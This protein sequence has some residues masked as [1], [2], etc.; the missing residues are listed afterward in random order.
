MIILTNKFLKLSNRYQQQVIVHS[1]FEQIIKT[2]GNE[3]I[4]FLEDRIETLITGDLLEMKSRI[5]K[6]FC[7]LTKENKQL[8]KSN[9]GDVTK[10]YYNGKIH[11]L[12]ILQ[13]VRP[14]IL[15]MSFY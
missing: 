3:N 11:Q 9:D 15:E 5:D 7:F 13:Q 8:L 6:N 10:P 1:I 12:N 2:N 14:K 4:P